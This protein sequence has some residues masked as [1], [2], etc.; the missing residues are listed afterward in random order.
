MRIKKFFYIKKFLHNNYND[1]NDDDIFV[2]L[3]RKKIWISY[4]WLYF[5]YF[6]L[7]IKYIYLYFITIE[8]NIV[9]EIF[10]DNS[11]KLIKIYI[12]TY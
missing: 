4:A 3:T 2:M 11:K 6:A 1:E 9:I 7:L 12:Y 5:N 8:K 10:L